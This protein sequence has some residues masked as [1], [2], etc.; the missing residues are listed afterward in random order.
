MSADLSII[1]L[2]SEENFAITVDVAK[3]QVIALLKTHTHTHTLTYMHKRPKYRIFGVICICVC[4]CEW[5]VFEG[6]YCNSAGLSNIYV[7][8]HN[9]QT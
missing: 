7:R 4:I 1:F 5:G 8:C 3:H 6:G 9:G 2:L